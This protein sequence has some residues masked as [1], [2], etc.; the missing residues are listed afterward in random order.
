MLTLRDLLSKYEQEC[1]AFTEFE[2]LVEVLARML[3]DA[4]ED[5]QTVLKLVQ[6]RDENQHEFNGLL[7]K[8]QQLSQER[9][10]AC[11][12]VKLLED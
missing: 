11:Q 10:R 6:E 8:L 12:R 3:L 2:Q 1:G 9:D 5:K 4:N 7:Y